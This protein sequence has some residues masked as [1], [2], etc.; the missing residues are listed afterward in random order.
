MSESSAYTDD[1]AV[2]RRVLAGEIDAFEEI[3]NRWQGPLINLAFRFFR[4]RGKAEEMAQEAFMKIYR[5]L[6]K[7]RQDSRFSTWAYTV[8]MNHYRSALRRHAPPTID[9]EELAPVTAG[10]DLSDEIDDRLQAEAVHRA[11]ATL[12][13]KYREVVVLF[14]FQEKDLAETARIAELREGTVKARLFRA[15]KLLE[16]RLGALI[17]APGAQPAEA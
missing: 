4:D 13:P 10:G 16:Q 5:G 15:R 7:W 3:V 1:A 2:I 9:F 11:V 8:A 14:Y 6:P 17:L 12:P